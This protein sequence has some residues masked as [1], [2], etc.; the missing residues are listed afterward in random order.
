MVE[1]LPG[2]HKGLGTVPSIEK[3]DKKRK[4]IKK[5]M[6]RRVGFVAMKPG[7]WDKTVGSQRLNPN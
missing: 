7:E 1:C 3:K 6:K 2:T 5:R 4:K